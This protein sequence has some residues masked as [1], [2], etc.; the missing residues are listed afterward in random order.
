MITRLILLSLLAVR[1]QVEH[2]PT[3]PNVP[4]RLLYT[5]NVDVASSRKTDYVVSVDRFLDR[6]EIESLVCDIFAKEKP[7][8]FSALWIWIFYKV[9]K[10]VN[11]FLANFD[12][13]IFD[14]ELANYGWNS[15]APD[16]SRRLTVLKDTDGHAYRP[17]KA[18]DFDHTHQ[19]GS[20]R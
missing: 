7:V 9:D 10:Y 16:A 14:R 5:G 2:E 15:N 6:S 11:P 1:L 12:N 18:F 13:E 19:C 20:H 17:P 3:K 8:T 4:Y